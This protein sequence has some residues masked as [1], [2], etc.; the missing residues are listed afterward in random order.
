VE[1]TF[2]NTEGSGQSIGS[3]ADFNPA[4]P[5]ICLQSWAASAA[6]IAHPQEEPLEC[7]NSL[8]EVHRHLV[9]EHRHLVEARSQ[10]V[11]HSRLVVEGSRLVEDILQ[12]TALADTAEHNPRVPPLAGNI[13]EDIDPVD[14]DL[15]CKDLG[16]ARQ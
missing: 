4:T 10:P 11:E 2:T 16:R 3:Q 7:H 1:T 12:G 8:V 6:D 5:L 13:L 15:A 9:E 14:T